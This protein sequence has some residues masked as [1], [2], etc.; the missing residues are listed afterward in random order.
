MGVTGLSVDLELT[1]G[2]PVT[3]GGRRAPGQGIPLASTLPKERERAMSGSRPEPV[4]LVRKGE[5]TKASNR[6]SE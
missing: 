5:S 2:F 3:Y 4:N 6:G 1:P